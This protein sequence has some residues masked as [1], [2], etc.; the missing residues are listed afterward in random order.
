MAPEGS[1]TANI[2]D[3]DFDAQRQ[4]ILFVIA[5]EGNDGYLTDGETPI[6]GYRVFN[7]V[8]I[9]TEADRQRVNKAGRNMFDSKLA[10]LK[11]QFNDLG[12]EVKTPDDI[13]DAL[14]SK[15]WVGIPL[16]IKVSQNEWDG[17]VSNR[18]DFM[19]RRNE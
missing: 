12:V 18:V 5:L 6:D 1:Y 19:A 17:K 13:A 4:Q 2:V 14:E 10:M 7:R 16:V 8:N 11:R 9:P 15:A 3:T